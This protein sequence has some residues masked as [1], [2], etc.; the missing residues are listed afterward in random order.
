M[1]N[2]IP[3]LAMLVVLLSPSA[4]LATPTCLS[5]HKEVEFES[6]LAT[7][8]FW[9]NYRNREGS[10][11]YE[12][13]EMLNAADHQAEGI[14]SRPK[15]SGVCNNGTLFLVFRS[16]PTKRL[17]DYKDFKHCAELEKETT[18]TPI[19]YSERRFKSRDEA[20]DWYHRL[21]QG[22]GSDGKDLYRRC[23]RDCSP[24]Y[25]TLVTKHDKQFVL[26]SRITCGHARDKDDNTYR[27]SSA[28]IWSCKQNN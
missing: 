25:T 16:T 10:V 12:M 20:K 13:E 11:N 17:T 1:R 21:T 15:C 18:T 2:L 7:A 4:V 26:T 19:V 14:M 27:L 3:K 8:G 24:A 5:L 9:A 22:K 23:D 28:F 6:R